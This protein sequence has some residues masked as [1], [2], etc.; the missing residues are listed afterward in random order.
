MPPHEARLLRQKIAE[1]EAN[2]AIKEAQIAALAR[3]RRPVEPVFAEIETLEQFLSALFEELR[4][5]R[6]PHLQLVGHA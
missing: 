4:R 2:I 3:M 1:C 5:A 6:L